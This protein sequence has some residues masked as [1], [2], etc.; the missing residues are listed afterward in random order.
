[1]R[2]KILKSKSN[3]MCRRATPTEWSKY[4]TATMVMKTLRHE[5]PKCIFDILKETLYIT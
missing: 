4:A 2:I 1:M 3:K 5:E